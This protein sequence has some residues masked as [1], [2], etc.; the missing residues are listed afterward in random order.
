VKKIFK[1]KTTKNKI[2]TMNA[3]AVPF[4]WP[5]VKPSATL[6]S[7]SNFNN[8]LYSSM[9]LTVKIKYLNTNHANTQ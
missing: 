9:T 3:F 5:D 8:D 7:K 6:K 2:K 1:E 4:L